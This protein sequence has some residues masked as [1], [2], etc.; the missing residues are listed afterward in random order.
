MSSKSRMEFETRVEGPF[1]SALSSWKL[2]AFIALAALVMLAAAWT[3]PGSNV[4]A[5][6]DAA[7]VHSQPGQSSSWAITVSFGDGT[8]ATGNVNH[9]PAGAGQA[10]TIRVDLSCGHTHTLHGI[11]A[12]SGLMHGEGSNSVTPGHASSASVKVSKHSRR[13]EEPSWVGNP[14]S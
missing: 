11:Q 7:E 5:S 14:G 3:G 12:G 6:A 13:D 10:V 2:A 8:S 4:S 9:E 1:V